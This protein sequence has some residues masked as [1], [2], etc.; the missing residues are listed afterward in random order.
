MLPHLPRSTPHPL[1]NCLAAGLVIACGF[2]ISPARASEATEEDAAVLKGE[3]IEEVAS[4]TALIDDLAS[5]LWR[6]AE[7]ALEE[8]RSAQLLMSRLDEAGFAV[9]AGVAGMPTAF[10]A[11]WGSGRP[12][13][14]FLGEYDVESTDWTPLEPRSPY[15]FFVRVDYG[16]AEEYEQGWKVTEAMPVNGVGMTTARDHVVIDYEEEQLLERASL[17]RDSVDSDAELC[18]QLNIPQKKGWNIANA[19]RLIRKET[20]LHQHIKPV[21]YRP[22][23]NRLIFYHDSLVW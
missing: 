16:L 4:R 12:F 23:D 19:R 3:A 5:E 17:F 14:G 6:F 13:I 22:F 9:E 18:R 10:V 8:Q 15:Y 21:L 11:T 7:L 20:N 2:A 1:R